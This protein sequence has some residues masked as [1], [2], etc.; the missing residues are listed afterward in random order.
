MCA[1]SAR[2]KCVLQSGV[3]TMPEL[4]PGGR[5]AVVRDIKADPGGAMAV[6]ESETYR[7][8]C[9][10]H[11]PGVPVYTKAELSLL[12]RLK[13]GAPLFRGVQKI[14]KVFGRARVV[15]V[16]SAEE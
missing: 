14:K 10:A 8:P 16:F 15:K 1:A 6:V 4:G 12:K 5:W 13:H 11:N 2:I 3:S 7:A 9:I